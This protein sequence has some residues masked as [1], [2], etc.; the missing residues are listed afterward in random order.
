MF[1]L[2]GDS[3]DGLSLVQLAENILWSPV[4]KNPGTDPLASISTV[5]ETANEPSQTRGAAA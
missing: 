1:Q 3:S 2:I 5:L 4:A